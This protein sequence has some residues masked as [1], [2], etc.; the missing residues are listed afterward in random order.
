MSKLVHFLSILRTDPNLCLHKHP[1]LEEILKKFQISCCH[2]TQRLDLI[3]SPWNSEEI[4]CKNFSVS[5]NSWFSRRWLIWIHILLMFTELGYTP[6]F[7]FLPL[8]CRRLTAVIWKSQLAWI[9]GWKIDLKLWFQKVYEKR[10]KKI[11]RFTLSSA[12]RSWYQSRSCIVML[13]QGSLGI[14]PRL[15]FIWS[16]HLINLLMFRNF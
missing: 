14:S 7:E 4:F 13:N 10:K 16:K 6:V 2:V 3:Q 5:E 8:L 1:L 12:M 9:T 11:A 15:Y